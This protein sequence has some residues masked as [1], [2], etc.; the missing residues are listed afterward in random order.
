MAADVFAINPSGGTTS[1]ATH[2]PVRLPNPSQLH[3]L[4]TIVTPTVRVRFRLRSHADQSQLQNDQNSFDTDLIATF[5]FLQ[6][7]Q[8]P[9]RP[10]MSCLDMALYRP[11]L[12]Q[13][14]LARI[15]AHG[16]QPAH[17]PVSEGTRARETDL[18]KRA[19]ALTEMMKTRVGMANSDLEVKSVLKATWQL[20]SGPDGDTADLVLPAGPRSDDAKSDVQR[21]ARR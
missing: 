4:S 11:T 14:D 16:V 19:S 7:R 1:A 9:L 6:Y 18:T 2:V 13:L 20:P 5:T 15:S 3:P 10:G 8:N 12:G 17:A 21:S